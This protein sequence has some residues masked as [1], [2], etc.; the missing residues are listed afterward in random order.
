MPIQASIVLHLLGKISLLIYDIK[1]HPV[2]NFRIMLT[3]TNAFL[4]TDIPKQN[5]TQTWF[6]DFFNFMCIIRISRQNVACVDMCMM[7][8]LL[9]MAVT[10]F[11]WP[12]K[13]GSTV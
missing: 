13:V 4:C 3:D 8:P 10:L 9:S 5:V 11:M 1:Q 6:V 12:L 2:L 7:L